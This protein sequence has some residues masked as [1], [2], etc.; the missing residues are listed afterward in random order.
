MT[1]LGALIKSLR[2]RAGLNQPELA[3]KAKVSTAYIGQLEAGQKRNPSL[4]VLKRIAKA[5]GVPAAE[6][7]E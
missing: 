1:R 2:L 3:R 4:D 7:L 5:L 6:L